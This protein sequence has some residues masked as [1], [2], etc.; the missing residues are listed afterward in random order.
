MQ[1]IS[2]EIRFKTARSGGKGGQH[3]NKVE[4]QAEG[5]WKIGETSYFSPEQIGILHEKLSNRINEN[6]ELHLK[7]G[8]SRSQLSN[9]K[10]VIR[11]MNELV[12]RAL[13]KKKPRIST[14]PTR[15]SREN[16][17]KNKK[18]RSE[19]KQSRRKFPEE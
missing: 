14:L 10:T 7:C 8:E 11:R 2:G 4:T 15:A 17:I 16:R 5:F 1:D 18:M 6:G 13:V 12:S 19:L 9:K 3:V